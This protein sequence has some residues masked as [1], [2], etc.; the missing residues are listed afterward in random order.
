MGQVLGGFRA[1]LGSTYDAGGGRAW[2]P[3]AFS[4]ELGHHL[5]PILSTWTAG[6]Y[7]LAMHPT[8]IQKMPMK[9]DLLVKTAME[10]GHFHPVSGKNAT[11]KDG[12]LVQGS[13]P[14]LM[15]HFL[16]ERL[17]GKAGNGGLFNRV[18]LHSELSNALGM[19]CWVVKSV[20]GSR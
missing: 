4:P 17:P 14:H 1:R 5:Y 3:P 16:P 19:M 12:A 18:G 7:L 10:A 9:T 20:G 15:A 6:V 2:D 8:C 11:K 13:P